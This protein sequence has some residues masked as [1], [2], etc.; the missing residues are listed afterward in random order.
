M[1]ESI[2]IV[3]LA[4]L[5]NVAAGAVAPAWRGPRSAWAERHVGLSPMQGI[6]EPGPFR[7][8]RLPWLAAWLDRRERW[9][10]YKGTI[11]MK[12][13]QAGFT[14][15][16][17]CRL[18][19]HIANRSGSVLY[20][21]GREEELKKI[22]RTRFADVT[23][24]EVIKGRMTL[25]DEADERAQTTFSYP[26]VA[27][28]VVFG[29]G[30]SPSTYAS[31][32]YVEAI[33]DE[34]DLVEKNFPPGLGTPFE[35][36]QGRFKRVPGGGYLTTFSHPTLPNKG[37]AA[38]YAEQSTLHRWLFDCPH[39]A[40]P[41][42]LNSHCIRFNKI[43]DDGRSVLSE[44]FILACPR[45]GGD[46]DEDYRTAAVWPA[47][48]PK[49]RAGSRGLIVPSG[50]L[51][52]PM[53]DVDL[54]QRVYLGFAVNGLMDPDQPAAGLA[55][56]LSVTEGDEAARQAVVNVQFGEA[57]MRRSANIEPA[58]LEKLM[59]EC[60]PVR[61][62]PDVRVV[63]AGSDVQAPDSNPTIYTAVI[64]WTGDG[65]AHVI[66]LRKVQGFAAYNQVLRTAGVESGDRLMGVRA[67]AVDDRWLGGQVKDDARTR[68]VSTSGMPIRKLCVGFQPGNLRTV[69]D[70]ITFVPR[71][72][73]RVTDPLRP[74]L[75][76]VEGYDLY[77]HAWV[78][79]VLKELQDGRLRLSY[80]IGGVG[81]PGKAELLSH[82]TAQ[83]LVVVKATTGFDDQRL[84]WARA[85][86][87]RDD[88]LMAIVYA[89]VAAVLGADLG[90][91][92]AGPV[93]AGARK[94]ITPV[95]GGSG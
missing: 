91:A 8:G 58:K 46:I 75:G 63:A 65:V 23:R 19:E 34:Y 69:N 67:A 54:A 9:P 7:T 84:V 49:R 37:V 40:A 38:L 56:K 81:R 55:R 45:C 5:L 26:F 83:H 87:T 72:E 17:L 32:T 22:S 33:I 93:V 52:T 47:D 53:E 2:D 42:D 39:C 28:E 82:L 25:V 85:K 14:L 21:I 13:A 90:R 73:R 62:L 35:Y 27:G 51:W 41:C 71:S 61:S 68:T 89:Y 11:G 57:Y 36:V 80:A 94:I 78:D 92:L 64:A 30:G 74:E 6:P 70:D 43:G 10:R 3:E 1:S 59:N 29:S 48:G 4:S 86:D 50:R 31:T 24:H 15:S 12:I 79:R 20:S 60:T 95:W 76:V 16:E 88:W 44:G 66:D 18:A 77:R